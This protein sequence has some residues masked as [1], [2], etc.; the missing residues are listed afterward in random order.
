MEDTMR[1]NPQQ[2]T[3]DQKTEMNVIKAEGQKFW[4]LINNLQKQGRCTAL[5]KTKTEEAVMWAVK[6]ITG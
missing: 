2:L 4:N 1:A 3:E 6:E 5:A